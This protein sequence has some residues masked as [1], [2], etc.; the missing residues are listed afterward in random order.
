MPDT[1]LSFLYNNSFNT[2]TL[3]WVLM[4]SPLYRGGIQSIGRLGD[5]FDSTRL[6]WL[7]TVAKLELEHRHSG[8]RVHPVNRNAVTGRILSQLGPQGCLILL[9]S[10]GLFLVLPPFVE[11]LH[12]LLTF[13]RQL[14]FPLP[15]ENRLDKKKKTTQM[16]Q[17][18][19][20]IA[21]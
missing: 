8:C 1:V 14:N 11:A 4:L 7:H 10:F 9:P 19:S 18:Q 16:E 2:A 20:N 5:L 13:C 21:V 6:E 12:L 3:R 15:G 17:Q